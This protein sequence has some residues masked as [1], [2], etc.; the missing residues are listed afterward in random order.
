MNITVMFLEGVLFVEVLFHSNDTGREISGL[1]YSMSSYINFMGH[2][3]RR[4]ISL[5]AINHCPRHQQLSLWGYTAYAQL[6]P[7]RNCVSA[8]LSLERLE[9]ARPWSLRAIEFTWECGYIYGDFCNWWQTPPH[10]IS[11]KLQKDLY[12]SDCRFWW[13]LV[14]TRAGKKYP[15]GT[16]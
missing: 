5:S 6:S 13:V 9:P 1:E 7:L 14:M 4:A 10:R 8:T 11:L 16:Y 2:C 3:D 15:S 12:N